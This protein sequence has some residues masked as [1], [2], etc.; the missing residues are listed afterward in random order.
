VRWTVTTIGLLDDDLPR[1]NDDAGSAVADC[2]E[3]IRR[4]EADGYAH[5]GDEHVIYGRRWTRSLVKDT[6]RV[7]V[8][9]DAPA[10]P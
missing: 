7:T 10:P 6:H 4:L 2:D 9:L 5:E 1:H 3:Q 8:Q